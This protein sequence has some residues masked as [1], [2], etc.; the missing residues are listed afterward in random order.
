MATL[1]SGPSEREQH[2]MPAARGK[3]FPMSSAAARP[4]R[5]ER[6]CG[7]WAVIMSQDRCEVTGTDQQ[8]RSLLLKVAVSPFV[9]MH[10]YVLSNWTDA[11]SS[12]T[13]LYQH[14]HQNTK[15]LPL[16]K[17][18]KQPFHLQDS[19]LVQGLEF[20]GTQSKTLIYFCPFP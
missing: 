4:A 15:H 3:C 1:A 16:P 10:L 8:V 2:H 6:S 7:A 12:T 18:L 14:K 5:R 11:S 9:E 19:Y 13:Y 20:S 17:C